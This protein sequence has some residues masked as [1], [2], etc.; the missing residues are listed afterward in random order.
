[1]GHTHNEQDQRFSQMASCIARA[2]LLEDMQ[3][4]RDWIIQ[5]F[6]PA[7]GRVP[8]C[9]IVEVTMNFQKWLTHFGATVTGLVATHTEPRS[10]HV[11]RSIRRSD[12][13][14]YKGSQDW[15]VH[16][17]HADWWSEAMG[18]DDTILLLKQSM[19]SPALSQMPQL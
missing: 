3:Q 19:A 14:G 5:N 4:C 16:V 6:K 9:E 12:L 18:D 8:V 2:G 15:E 17:G 7:R 13:G 1:M 10:C 11:W